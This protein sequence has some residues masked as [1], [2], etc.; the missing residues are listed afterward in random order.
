MRKMI[1]AFLFGLVC[2]SVYAQK[3]DRYTLN[4]DGAE[5]LVSYPDAVNVG[6]R[7]W[8]HWDLKSLDDKAHPILA[9]FCNAMECDPNSS[10]FFLTESVP[11]LPDETVMDH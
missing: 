8:M 10:A 7:V 3:T 2:T 1:I 9:D 11:G 5:V 6:V 4:L